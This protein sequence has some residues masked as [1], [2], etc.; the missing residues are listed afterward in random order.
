MHHYC[1]T[2]LLG[3]TL[4]HEAA[5][6]SV[7]SPHL[8]E[9]LLQGGVGSSQGRQ[10]DGSRGGG[11][12]G[13]GGGSGGAFTVNRAGET[14]LALV[15]RAGQLNLA[16][17]MIRRAL[18]SR[19]G[20]SP[21]QG[22][23]SAPGQ[24]LP[25]TYES[26][27][28]HHTIAHTDTTIQIRSLFVNRARARLALVELR[29]R[30]LMTI[31]EVPHHVH[32]IQYQQMVGE[33]EG[34]V[35]R[36]PPPHTP[37]IGDLSTYWLY[38]YQSTLSTIRS[39]H[40]INPPIRSTH[41]IFITHL[42]IP[43]PPRPPL[44]GFGSQCATL[45]TLTKVMLQVSNSSTASSL[46][47]PCHSP[48]RHP[49]HHPPCHPRHPCQPLVVITVFPQCEHLW[50]RI[51]QHDSSIFVRFVQLTYGATRCVLDSLIRA[52]RVFTLL[53]IPFRL[54]HLNPPLFITTSKYC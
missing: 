39:T 19:P 31:D 30:A 41:P 38:L 54:V 8:V 3:H 6:V 5:R 10:D 40:P 27:C 14:P 46:H 50:S 49:P 33:E 26:I 52:K 7:H 47:S 43:P 17:K 1:S 42:L 23:A 34:V 11:N 18:M 24:G 29:H 4:L 53:G 2:S 20:L 36:V 51:I 48:L 28:E 25:L 32:L 21:G 35:R 9:E 37:V 16:T 13:G 12:G 45:G 15:L 44:I 22:L